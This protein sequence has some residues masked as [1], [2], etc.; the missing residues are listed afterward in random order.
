MTITDE[1]PEEW[2]AD[3]VAAIERRGWTV[4][5]AHESAITVQL[6][7][8]EAAVLGA[9]PGCVLVIGWTERYGIDWGLS[10][11][12][13]AT[14]DEAQSMTEEAVPEAIAA[15]VDRLMLVGRPD[16]RLVQ[17]AMPAAAASAACTCETVQPCGGIVPDPDCPDH[18][19]RRAP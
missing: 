13:S 14:V 2:V 19:A 8:R 10:A 12:G 3:V 15:A 18:G 9:D 5:D 16:A 1:M 11:D 6:G 7:S 4:Q 17:H